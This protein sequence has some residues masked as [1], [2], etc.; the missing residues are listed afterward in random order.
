[1]IK[2][3]QGFYHFIM[4][5]SVLVCGALL[6]F[7]PSTGLYM[8]AIGTGLIWLVA[9]S[10]FM[11]AQAKTMIQQTQAGLMQTVQSEV[12]QSLQSTVQSEV[13]SVA[14]QII[15]EVKAEK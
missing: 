2:Y 5:F 15:Q 4:C 11:P 12:A 13:T 1:M 8:H 3:A 10:W 9:V 7:M 14:Q 6:V